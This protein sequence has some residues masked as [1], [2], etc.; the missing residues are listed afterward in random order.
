MRIRFLFY[1]I[2]G[3]ALEMMFV[4]DTNITM[5]KLLYNMLLFVNHIKECNWISVLN[6]SISIQ[7]VVLSINMYKTVQCFLWVKVLPSQLWSVTP[8][9]LMPYATNSHTQHF[10]IFSFFL[11]HHTGV[12]SVADQRPAIVQLSQLIRTSWNVYLN[13]KFFCFFYF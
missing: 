7:I 9:L 4:N 8:S 13:C 5:F 12:F 1:H 6:K 2:I 3:S 11:H 10:W